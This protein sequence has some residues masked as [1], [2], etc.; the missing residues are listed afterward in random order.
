MQDKNKLLF[1]LS[2]ISFLVSSATIL[3]MP[4]GSFEPDGNILLA[5]ILAGLF[6]LFLI[7]G[8]VFLLVLNNRRKKD[9]LNARIDGIGL[10]RFFRN[11][12]AIVFDLLLFAGIVTLI[13][14][15]LV[16]RTLPSE[17]TLAGTFTTV[18]S[19]EMHSLFN[20]KNYAWL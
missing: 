12:P 6:W 9:I 5:Y 20:G 18:F 16:L 17:I 4:Y 1:I 13:V 2:A 11:K 19:L 10:F 14:S 7:L 8:F 15:L 3:L